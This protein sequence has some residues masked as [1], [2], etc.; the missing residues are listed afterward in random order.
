MAIAAEPRFVPSG[1]SV[2]LEAGEELVQVDASYT[3]VESWGQAVERSSRAARRSAIWS[4]S[5]KSLGLIT[6]RLD[7]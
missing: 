7:H 1:G 6:L 3:P 4:V 2:S 5:K